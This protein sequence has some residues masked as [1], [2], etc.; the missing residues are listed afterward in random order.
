MIKNISGV[1][2]A[3]GAGK[4]FRGTIKP[5]ILVEGKPII[6]RILDS[7]DG[8]FDEIIIVT[9]TPDEFIGYSSCI[10]TGDQFLNRG[11]L[12]GIHAALKMTGREAIFVVAGDMPYLDK[13]YILRQ[14][15]SFEQSYCQVLI[16][17]INNLIEPLHAIYR[18]NILNLLEDYLIRNNDN[19][20]RNFIGLTE[21]RYL[22]T[23]DSEDSSKAFTNINSPSDIQ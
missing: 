18:R 1:I 16:P 21:V 8:I 10:I 22:Q 7:F 12:G 11:P 23:E 4:R 9:N 2:L 5:K 13:S 15:E 6:S 17:K 20:I 19:A 14:I 3:G